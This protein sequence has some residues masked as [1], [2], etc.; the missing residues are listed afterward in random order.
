MT[1]EECKEQLE[2]L[3]VTYKKQ[4]IAITKEMVKGTTN[5]YGRKYNIDVRERIGYGVQIS[6]VGND[7]SCVISYEAMLNIA[8]AMGLFDE[9]E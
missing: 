7:K 8:E 2:E 1:K 4:K 3:G 9:N 5:I 6:T